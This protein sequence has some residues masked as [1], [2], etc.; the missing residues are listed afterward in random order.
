MSNTTDSVIPEF[1]LQGLV[2]ASVQQDKEIDMFILIKANKLYRE[3]N[4]KLIFQA[5][6]CYRYVT[7]WTSKPFSN[8]SKLLSIK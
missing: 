1:H 3:A 7:M 6:T 4:K 8:I 2:H 5:S